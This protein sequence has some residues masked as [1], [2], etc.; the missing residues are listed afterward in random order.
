[1]SLRVSYSVLGKFVY[2]IFN[3]F[4]QL[5]ENIFWM[6]DPLIYRFQ[7]IVST[8][9]FI[10]I[11]FHFKFSCFID[12]FLTLFIWYSFLAYVHVFS[13]KKKYIHIY[14]FIK[15]T[16][17]LFKSCRLTLKVARIKWGALTISGII[18]FGCK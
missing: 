12:F 4:M 3:F 13:K 7:L 11:F 5:S 16:I 17:K 9:I 14:F 2:T 10:N 1:M 8:T 6:F 18:K 15:D